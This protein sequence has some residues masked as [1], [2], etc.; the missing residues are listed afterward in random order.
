M[1]ERLKDYAKLVIS[2]FYFV[3]FRLLYRLL[4]RP[5]I[6]PVFNYHG[7]EAGE[8]ARFRRQLEFLRKRWRFVPLTEILP[9]LEGAA[10]QP[11]IAHLCFDDALQVVADH[12]LPVLRELA[13]P[14]TIFVPTSL[15]GGRMPPPGAPD[16]IMD[17]PT[18]LALESPAVRFESHT[19][20]HRYL[21]DLS[22]R[23]Q[24]QELAGSRQ[25]LAARLGRDVLCVAYP[26][27]LCN[28]DI[29][30]RASECGY[31]IGFSTI[32]HTDRSSD[33]FDVRRL[34]LRPSFSLLEVWLVT[35]GG[36][37]WL[38]ILAAFRRWRRRRQA[39]PRASGR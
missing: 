21:T 17:W 37:N 6:L 7:I 15:A 29:K 2:L 26:R 22:P 28:E 8:I 3:F 35:N 11:G 10:F 1:T 23:E 32:T 38:A 5:I 20:T 4:A 39:P 13:I 12:A 9:A 34:L 16:A 24:E 33:P 19:A 25:T 31:R 14:C 27:G 30:R 18:I 36:Y